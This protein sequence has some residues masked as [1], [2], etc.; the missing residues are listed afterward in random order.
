MS[1]FESRTSYNSYNPNSIGESK[2]P[3]ASRYGVIS[4]AIIVINRLSSSYSEESLN[5]ENLN[6]SSVQV[7]ENPIIEAIE[8]SLDSA[9]GNVANA[10]NSF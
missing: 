4:A 10:Y 5:T 8:Q 2:S 9:R 7:D 1:L 3:E 6:G